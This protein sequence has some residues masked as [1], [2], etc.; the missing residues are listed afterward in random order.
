MSQASQKIH[1]PRR[2]TKFGKPVKRVRIDIGMEVDMP[3]DMP[4]NLIRD[5]LQHLADRVMNYALSQASQEERDH[6]QP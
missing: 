6:H 1:E 2:A 3:K 5:Y 4:D